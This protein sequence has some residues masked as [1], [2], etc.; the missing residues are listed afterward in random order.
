M[1]IPRVFFQYSRTS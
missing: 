1:S